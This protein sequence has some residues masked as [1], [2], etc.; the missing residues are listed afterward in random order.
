MGGVTMPTFYDTF[1]VNGGRVFA[2]HVPI[3]AFVT[4]GKVKPTNSYYG[5]SQVFRPS[6]TARAI[7][8]GT[9][10]LACPGGM[11]FVM[12]GKLLAFSLDDR[13]PNDVGSFEKH[14]DPTNSR[15]MRLFE[16]GDVRLMDEGL[17]ES[18]QRM[19]EEWLKLRA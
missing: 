8:K 7:P 15:L 16:K 13:N 12:G 5:N 1:M 14:Y 18:F 11:W 4:D 19:Y 3:N 2:T 10:L 6:Y 9:P 17:P